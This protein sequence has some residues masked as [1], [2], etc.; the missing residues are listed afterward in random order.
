MPSRRGTDAHAPVSG[1]HVPIEHSVS[2][3]VQSTGD[4]GIFPSDAR[5]M[6]D[7]MGAADKTIEWLPGDHYFQHSGSRDDV[8]DLV[9]SWIRSKT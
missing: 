5:E 1:S 2:L 4:A 8:A 6:F 3:L 9:S 7:L